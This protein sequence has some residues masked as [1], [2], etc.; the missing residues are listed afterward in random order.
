MINV[1]CIVVLYMWGRG[2]KSGQGGNG[3]SFIVVVD[4]NVDIFI[5]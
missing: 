3:L 2:L 1:C 4:V 5:Q